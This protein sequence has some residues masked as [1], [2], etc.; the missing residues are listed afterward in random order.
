MS[1]AEAIEAQ[2]TGESAE[3]GH[4]PFRRGDRLPFSADLQRREH[5]V[6]TIAAKSGKS[7]A[8]PQGRIKLTELIPPIAEAFLRDKIGI[9]HALLIARLPQSRQQEAFDAAFRQIYTSDGNVQVLMPV[10]E[11]SAWVE[12]NFC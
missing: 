11:L 6:A 9:G 4:S 1:A 8:Y 10:R 7:A 12:T 3:A 5:T 2:I